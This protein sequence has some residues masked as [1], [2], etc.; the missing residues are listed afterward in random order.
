ME[1]LI[2]IDHYDDGTEPRKELFI[3]NMKGTAIGRGKVKIQ[4]TKTEPEEESQGNLFAIPAQ[5]GLRVT[6]YIATIDIQKLGD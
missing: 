4:D 2:H 3:Y 5:A 6:S 1:V